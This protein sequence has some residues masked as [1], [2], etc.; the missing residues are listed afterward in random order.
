[1]NS[2]MNLLSGDIDEIL[3]FII[4]FILLFSESRSE[5]NN[6]DRSYSNDKDIIL[7]FII[8]FGLLF[9]DKDFNFK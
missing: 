5:E 8:L 6:L 3:F 2:L 1:M 9:I 4:V 7:F